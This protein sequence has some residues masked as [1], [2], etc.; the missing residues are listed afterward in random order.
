MTLQNEVKDGL[1]LHTVEQQHIPTCIRDDELG[2]GE[3]IADLRIEEIVDPQGD[4][5]ETP[6][7]EEAAPKEE[8]DSGIPCRLGLEVPQ[9]VLSRRSTHPATGGPPR[10]LMPEPEPAVER[11]DQREIRR[12]DPIRLPIEPR[13]RIA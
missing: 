9:P 5:M 8:I 3:V 1:E 2:P 11:G 10:R 7:H 4:P 12:R 13:D 6:P